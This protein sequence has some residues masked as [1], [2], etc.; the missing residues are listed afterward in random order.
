M[1]ALPAQKIAETRDNLL[2]MREAL[3]TPE[4]RHL[5][6]ETGSKTA[7]DARLRARRCADGGG[8]FTPLVPRRFPLP[9]PWSCAQLEP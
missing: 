8:F 6:L 1:S 2:D 3:S 4:D 5:P 7:R 9:M